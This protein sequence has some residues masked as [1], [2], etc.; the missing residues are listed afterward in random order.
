MIMKTRFN[1]LT[2]LA[3][4]VFLV[5]CIDDGESQDTVDPESSASSSSSLIVLESSS[6]TK[7]LSSSSKDP[8][9]SASSK[10][11]S[12]ELVESSSSAYEDPY[13]SSGIFCWTEECDAESSSSSGT[14]VKVS[15]SSIASSSSIPTSSAT[16]SSS[17]T[18]TGTIV[19]GT[20]L[21]DLRNNEEYALVTTGGHLWMAENLRYSP[22]GATGIY[23]YAN[24]I[25]YVSTYGYLYTYTAAQTACPVGW[26]LPTRE[27]VTSG[28]ADTKT[29]PLLYAG[30]MSGSDFSYIDDMGFMWSS[31]T[32]ES[33]DK[34]HCS[35]ANCGMIL[36][37]KN[38][39]YDLNADSLQFFQRDEQAKGFS[40]RCV[41][42]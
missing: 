1:F 30:R 17:S 37:Q 26:H 15:S 39:N 20:K 38:P 24:D 5:G 4:A 34:D 42:D 13:F 21:V 11:S 6:S 33:T 23:A 25:S 28:I 14:P 18:G 35:V 31:A 7:I 27:E 2:I 16:V 32:F 40:V 41:Q 22:A 3:A 36:V 10:S 29:F 8:E 19:T 9:S 12:S